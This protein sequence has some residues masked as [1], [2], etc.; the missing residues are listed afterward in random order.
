MSFQQG[1][2]PLRPY[3]IPPPTFPPITSNIPAPP[4][5][6]A[7]YS[8]PPAPA[9]AKGP[10][11]LAEYSEYLEEKSP[12]E[13]IRGW[14]TKVG[15]QYSLQLI[16]QPFENSRMLLQCRVVPKGVKR[17]PLGEGEVDDDDDVRFS[18]SSR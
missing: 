2:N 12:K 6:S 16:A 4:I 14:F 11:I 1:H 15:I 3:Y 18:S 17:L 13:V 10:G 9:D 7:S 5:L 8:Y